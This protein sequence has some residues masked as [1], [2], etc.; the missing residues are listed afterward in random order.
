MQPGP[1]DF[2]QKYEVWIKNGNVIDPRRGIDK[3]MDVLVSKSKI[4]EF[5][6]DGKIEEREV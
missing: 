5:P 3:V 4:V 6:A 2:P 1:L